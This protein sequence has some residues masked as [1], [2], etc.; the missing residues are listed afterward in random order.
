MN[1]LKDLLQFSN[2]Q[3]IFEPKENSPFGKRLNFMQN[4][5]GILQKTFWQSE[6]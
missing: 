3:V 1:I 5:Q 6:Y 4:G 2:T